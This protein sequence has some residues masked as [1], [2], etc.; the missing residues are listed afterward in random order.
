MHA[1]RKRHHPISVPCLFHTL[2]VTCSVAFELVPH[3]HV[4]RVG[5]SFTSTMSVVYEAFLLCTTLKTGEAGPKNSYGRDVHSAAVA[6]GRDVHSAAVA[7][8]LCRNAAQNY[9]SSPGQLR[10][11]HEGL[12]FEVRQHPDQYLPPAQSPSFQQGNSPGF[13]GGRPHDNYPGGAPS[14]IAPL[15]SPF[16]PHS[17]GFG[18]RGGNGGFAQGFAAAATTGY[19]GNTPHVSYP[20]S[21]STSS[22][23]GGPIRSASTAS[24]QLSPALSPGHLQSKSS[25]ELIAIIQNMQQN[26]MATQRIP[27]GDDAGMVLSSLAPKISQLCENCYCV[28]TAPSSCD[29][30]CCLH[31]S[32]MVCVCDLFRCISPTI[33]LA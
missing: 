9:P 18:G 2:T 7:I 30:L 15:M 22:F 17:P 28:S 6:I 1:T 11:Q 27:Q 32:R 20:Q 3:P 23:Q 21:T 16:P 26:M 33:W 24:N 29:A 10:P 13:S 12:P 25:T 5:V 19:P 31:V 4:R 14:N 8:V